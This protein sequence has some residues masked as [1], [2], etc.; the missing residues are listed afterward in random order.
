M[1]WSPAPTRAAS[2]VSFAVRRPG[3]I[4]ARVG[5]LRWRLKT[6][7][8]DWGYRDPALPHRRWNTC[9]GS[10]AMAGSTQALPERRVGP[11][12]RG[13]GCAAVPVSDRLFFQHRDSTSKT[14][15]MT[16]RT[17]S[18]HAP[19]A[20][21]PVSYNPCGWTEKTQKVGVLDP[22][23]RGW[24]TVPSQWPP[25]V[26]RDPRG[27]ASGCAHSLPGSARTLGFTTE[28]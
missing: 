16:L 11:P 13:R 26:G 9:F 8:R 1:F 2:P 17:L 20:R 24:P 5:P 7:Q 22:S 27:G 4:A 21:Y 25:W 12:S 19:H 23:R 18:G 6:P 10:L 28:G 3:P 15:T 14:S